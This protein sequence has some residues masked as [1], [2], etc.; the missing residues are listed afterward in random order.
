MTSPTFW[1]TRAWRRVNGD[2]NH[3][4]TPTSAIAGKKIKNPL[5]ELSFTPANIMFKLTRAPVINTRVTWITMKS[6]NH[7]IARKWIDRAR[8]RLNTLPNQPSRFEIAG[9]CMNPV[10]MDT[11]AATNTVTK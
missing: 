7:H 5:Q 6:R 10:R 1:T 3:Q 2:A 9:P 11:G 8:C 4:V